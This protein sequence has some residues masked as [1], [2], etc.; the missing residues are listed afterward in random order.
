MTIDDDGT[1]LYNTRL[2]HG[3]ALHVSD[4]VTDRPGLE[5]Y[6]VHESPTGNG[7]IIASMRDAETG[8]VI[9]SNPGNRDTGRGAASRHRPDATRAPRR[10]P[11]AATTRGTRRSAR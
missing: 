11:S 7:G 3:D 4:F 8:E 10:G 1:P 5:V 2:H 6:A 9:W